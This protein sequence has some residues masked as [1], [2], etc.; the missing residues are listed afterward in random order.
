MVIEESNF[1]DKFTYFMTQVLDHDIDSINQ[2]ENER[3]R[4]INNDINATPNPKK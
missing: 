4:D 3:E 2:V 1:S